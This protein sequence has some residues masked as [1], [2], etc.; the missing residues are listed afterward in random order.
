M[1]LITKLFQEIDGNPYVSI[2]DIMRNM[3]DTLPSADDPRDYETEEG[4]VFSV[5]HLQY[6]GGI[7]NQKNEPLCVAHTCEA[8]ARVSTNKTRG[9]KNADFDS[10]SF[11]FD[12]LKKHDKMPY[13][14]GTTLK[15]GMKCLKKYGINE[16]GLFVGDFKIKRYS[17]ARN[18]KQAQ[19]A[20]QDGPVPACFRCYHSLF[21]CDG[22]IEKPKTGEAQFGYH[23]MTLIGMNDVGFNVVNSWGFDWGCLGTALFPFELYDIMVTEAWKC[24]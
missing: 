22:V 7:E 6:Y 23:A 11:Y 12:I 15:N 5:D 8:V 3:A 20:V 2:E 17:K 18:L 1:S 4:P 19:K 24:S 13:S 14:S 21:T 10:R 16:Q 9:T